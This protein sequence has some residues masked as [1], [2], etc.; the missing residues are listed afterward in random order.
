MRFIFSILVTLVM[1]KPASALE[2]SSYPVIETFI[3]EMERDHGFYSHELEQLFEEVEI[4]QDIIDI[5]NRP[6][7]AKPWHEYR[8]QFVTTLNAKRGVKFWKKWER[9]LEYA[10]FKYGVDSEIILGIIGVETQFGINKGRHRVIDALTTLA[11]VFPRRNSLFRKE[12]KNFLILTRE[13]KHN[14]LTVTGSYAGAIGLPQFLPSSY[15]QY[16]VDF[17]EDR[18]VNLMDSEIDAIGSIANYLKIH[19]W[20]NGEPVIDTAVLDETE[21][22]D[23]NFDNI[24]PRLSLAE[25]DD[26]GIRAANHAGNRDRKAVLLELEGKKESIYR[27]G[28]DNFYVITRYNKSTKYAMAVIELARLIRE[29]YENDK[30]QARP[31][32]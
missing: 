7:E 4:R 24:K 1:Y 3:E 27:I 21:L 11:F 12:L 22:E 31:A 14:P 18:K 28:F 10:K 19:G 23:Y 30:I 17:D 16:A 13:L 2:L 8:D 6:G 20:K 5:M 15:R 26:Y 32:S 29:M 9:P 25:L